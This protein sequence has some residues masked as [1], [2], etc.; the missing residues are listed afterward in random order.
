MGN[1][2]Y[3]GLDEVRVAYPTVDPLIAVKEKL[4]PS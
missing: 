1:S 2:M 3:N 4:G